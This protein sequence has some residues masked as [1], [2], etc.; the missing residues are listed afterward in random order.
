ME[1]FAISDATVKYKGW[2]ILRRYYG[3]WSGELRRNASTEN[4]VVLKSGA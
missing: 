3:M 4:R 2:K 1:L